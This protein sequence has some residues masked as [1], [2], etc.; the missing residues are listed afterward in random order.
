MEY[1]S[2]TEQNKIMCFVKIWM[3][4]EDIMLYDS[5]VT[6]SPSHVNLVMLTMEWSLPEA[7]NRGQMW[8]EEI[9]ILIQCYRF[10]WYIVNALKS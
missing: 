10:W 3:D 1:Y 5:N 6:S 2:A 9:D 8:R 4:S 7:G